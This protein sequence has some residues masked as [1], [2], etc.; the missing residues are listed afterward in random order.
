MQHMTFKVS[1]AISI[2]PIEGNDHV[3]EPMGS[4]IGQLPLAGTLSHLTIQEAGKCSLAMDPE[5]RGNGFSEQ[6]EITTT[7]LYLY[8]TSIFLQIPVFS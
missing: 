1:L 2:H 5:G 4:F 3:V 6:T 8:D 7:Y